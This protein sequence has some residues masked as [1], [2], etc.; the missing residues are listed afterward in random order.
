VH[1]EAHSFTVA[2]LELLTSIPGRVSAAATIDGGLR[3]LSEAARALV[4]AQRCCI[5]LADASSDSEGP[6]SADKRTA[7]RSGASS[8]KVPLLNA[9]GSLLGS[10]ELFGRMD[11]EF[12]ARDELLLCQL[13]RLAA[14]A[15]D[16]VRLR[17]RL[18]EQDERL[19]LALEAASLGTWEHIPSTH[20]TFWDARSKAMFG[21]G[22]DDALGYAEYTAAL[23]P[24]DTEYVFAGIAKAVDPAGPGECALQYRIRSRDGSER[25]V[26]AHGRC[27]FSDQGVPLR[28]NG[29]L[30]DITARKQAEDA[31]RESSRR[32]D[33]F[34]AL[35]G[36]E[37]RNPLAPIR[38]ALVLMRERA[39]ELLVREREVIERQ[40]LH[41]IRLVDDLL[42]LARISRGTIALKLEA[43]NVATIV[44]RAVEMASPL[45]EERGHRL[46]ISVADGLL[47]EA[48]AVRLS[49]VIANLLTNAARYT[50]VG[51]RIAVRGRR[52]GERVLLE[53]ED[54]GIGIDE[55][56][57]SSIFA[58]FFQSRRASDEK[59]G[60]LGL[61]LSLVGDLVRL[62]GGSVAARSAGVG[63][64]SCFSIDLP[65]ATRHEQRVDVSREV[66]VKAL[67]RTVLV[68]D[69]NEDAAEL[70]A[71]L[72]RLRGYQVRVAFDGPDALKIAAEFQPE[73][74]V[75]DLGLP[76]MDGC[77]LGARLRAQLG[78]ALRLVALTG[79]GQ[80]EDRA[81]TQ[82][83]GFDAH[84]VKPVDPSDLHAA[85]LN[86]KAP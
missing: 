26:E 64:G 43:V 59:Q 63:R 76:V 42:D 66:V 21:Y 10:I 57:L 15:L 49:Q 37:L 20:A 35:L 72:L 55:G 25:W 19:L 50:P 30:L 77:E 81:R 36:H 31:L 80:P 51:G 67:G 3:A 9:A 2:E 84:F 65:R 70:L 14:Q 54:D 7:A 13:A 62:H 82:Q 52:D 8:I 6:T 11:G 79:Y 69:D 12:D 34:L 83:A 78:P 48:D 16:S 22:P 23:H 29:T 28:I 17:T 71:Q 32:K 4:P 60:G 5:T 74:A 44:G 47:V 27:V 24:E 58:P 56:E 18:S 75:V 40:V 45:F 73:S 68:V 46:E 39:P 33:E 41:M 61:G 53:V 38:T 86:L 85:L 1:V